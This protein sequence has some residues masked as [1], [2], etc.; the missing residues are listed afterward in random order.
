MDYNNYDRGYAEPAMTAADYMSR[1][2]RWMACGLVLTFA[3]AFVT[4]TSYTMLSLVSSLYLVLTIAELALVFTL[5]ARVQ[6]M[7]IGT[8]RALFLAYSVL[9][10]MVLSFYFLAF[11]VGTLVMAFLSSAVYFGLMA[12]YGRTTNRDLTGWGPKLMLGL[13]ALMITSLIGGLFGFGFGGSLLY[14]GIG[15]VVFMLLTAYDTQKLHQVYA[16]YAY[17]SEM[18]ERASIYGALTLYLD[19]I[20]IFLFVVRL[21]GSRS[22]D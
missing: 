14:S 7:S 16:Y 1:T 5:S 6:K 12:V 3:T 18:A 21:M 20:N 11:S 2:Y 8:A 13:I 10:G 19:F 17:D 22:R 15:L 9:N 4:A